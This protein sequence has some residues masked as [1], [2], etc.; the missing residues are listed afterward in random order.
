MVP[1]ARPAERL[2]ETTVNLLDH[3]IHALLTHPARRPA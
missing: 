3:A 2:L 1:D